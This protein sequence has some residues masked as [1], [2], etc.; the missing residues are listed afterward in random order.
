MR[1]PSCPTLLLLLR[2]AQIKV[3]WKR[4]FCL[5]CRVFCVPAFQVLFQVV[6]AFV[7]AIKLYWLGKEKASCGPQLFDA[8]TGS[9][10]DARLTWHLGEEASDV[11]ILVSRMMAPFPNCRI[12]SNVSSLLTSPFLLCRV[13]SVPVVCRI[14]FMTFVWKLR[15][16]LLP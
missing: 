12:H 16:S 9:V 14:H 5:F 7:F 3:G 10:W 15:L 8:G 2:D 11:K 4:N 6:E 13:Y 1:R